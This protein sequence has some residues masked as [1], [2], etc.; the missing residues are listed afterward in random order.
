[1]LLGFMVT[2]WF[3]LP[4]ADGLSLARMATATELLPS[5]SVQSSRAMAAL[6]VA[7]SSS[8][9]TA[10]TKRD[11]FF[12]RRTW[13]SSQRPAETNRRKSLADTDRLTAWLPKQVTG[14]APAERGGLCSGL[15]RRAEQ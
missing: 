3:P 2:V 12:R 13:S 8:D 7:R 15:P 9:S 6:G 4:G 5:V 1:M 11:W 10:G 14:K